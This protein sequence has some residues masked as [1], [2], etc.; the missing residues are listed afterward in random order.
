MS[1]LVETA[2][3]RATWQA[4]LFSEKPNRLELSKLKASWPLSDIN[5]RI[6]RNHSFELVAS[7]THA[8]FGWWGQSPIFRY[9]DYDDSLSF[10]LDSGDNVDVEVLWIDLSRYLGR[11]HDD[12][13]LIEWL[14]NRLRALRFKTDAPI[15]LLPCDGNKD[16]LDRVITRNWSVSGIRVGDLSG[17][18]D[19]LGSGFHDERASKYSGT[20]LSNAACLLTAR[21]FA[22]RW[23]PALV[24]VRFKAI[25]VDLD[26]TLFHGVIGED[27]HNVVLTPAH[28]D[29]HR[30]L[31]KLRDQGIFL[32][33][34]SRNELNDV[35]GL[36]KSRNDFPL[37]WE[38]FSATQINWNRKSENIRQIA[39]QLRI[40]LDAVVFIDDNSG[41]LAEVA[42]D[43]SQVSLI[44]ADPDPSISQRTLEYFPGL[45]AWTTSAEDNLRIVDMQ[46][47]SERERL[48]TDSED[49]VEYLKSLKVK[50]H[51]DV[52]PKNHIRRLSELSLKTNQ[53]NL[54]FARLSE[55]ALSDMLMAPEYRI[56]AI[57][58]SDRLSESGIIGLIIGR[59]TGNILNIEELAISCRALGRRLE[60]LMIVEAIRA[61]PGLDPLAEIKFSYRTGPRNAPA[62]DWL[63]NFTKES[64]ASEG[65]SCWNGTEQHGSAARPPVEIVIQTND[66]PHSNDQN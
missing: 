13:E 18:K 15:L 43:T 61:L 1:S 39:Q 38:H 34:V 28:A 23:I 26:Q 7:A 8:W 37:Q 17:I 31:L 44:H 41:E 40:G 14:E 45:W 4:C 50:L 9:S 21:E 64:L 19:T 20:R 3:I 52:D 54:N 10:D 35:R 49:P 56:A 22:C 42:S 27:G 2:M 32:A 66:A 55:I 59:L 24:K 63:A 16:L 29:L 12:A 30:A 60:T 62:L 36:F 33:L 48:A 6:H 65:Q 47:A 58:M 57:S 46:A 5:I 25:A 11:F 51:I 53:F